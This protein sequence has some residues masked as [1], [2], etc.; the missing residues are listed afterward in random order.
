MHLLYTITSSQRK[1]GPQRPCARCTRLGLECLTLPD[2]RRRGNAAG[3]SLAKTLAKSHV[4]LSAV[5]KQL[6][7]GQAGTIGSQNSLHAVPQF[8]ASGIF[9]ESRDASEPVQAQPSKF[10]IVGSGSAARPVTFSMSGTQT[11]GIVA[12]GAQSPPANGFNSG[13]SS[14]HQRTTSSDPISFGSSSYTTP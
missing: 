13:G 2:G 12:Q 9:G 1:C 5:E 8:P 7:D 3:L 6:V 14:Q 10:R 4:P 11:P